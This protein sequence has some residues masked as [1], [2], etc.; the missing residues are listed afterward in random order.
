[1]A[2]MDAFFIH[3]EKIVKSIDQP[4][5]VR[6]DPITNI[7]NLLQ[8]ISPM[9]PTTGNST[10]AKMKKLRSARK[11]QW[12]KLKEVWR[13]DGIEEWRKCSCIDYYKCNE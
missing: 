4:I 8:Q 2:A 10:S 9:S 5:V 6:M 11:K 1:M 7:L 3:T 13:C 12:E